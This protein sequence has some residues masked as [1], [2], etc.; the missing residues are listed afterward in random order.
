MA[1]F[2]NN[3]QSSIAPSYLNS[4][5]PMM[6]QGMIWVKDKNEAMNYP[7]PRGTILPIFDQNEDNIFYVKSV[8][9]YGNTQPLRSFKYE[10]I[11]QSED[12]TTSSK[13]TV[14]VEEFNELKEQLSSLQEEIK[15]LGESN[16]QRSSQY[17]DNRKPY[18]RKENRNG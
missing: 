12:G 4:M 11:T 1:L 8:D 14:S 5:A 2:N 15:K 10:E 3:Y 9:V 18:G 7:M 13:Q 16:A 6:P 17:S